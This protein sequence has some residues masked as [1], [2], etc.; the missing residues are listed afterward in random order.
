MKS[1]SS[2]GCFGQPTGRVWDAVRAGW[3]ALEHK[4]DEMTYLHRRPLN[5]N[6]LTEVEVQRL[7]VL[8]AKKHRTSWETG[9]AHALLMRAPFEVHER[10][11][12]MLASKNPKGR[13][14][15]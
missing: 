5:L 4:E 2:C 12:P 3:I 15:S 9:E 13:R 8:A 14:A 1:R 11:K 10:L 7:E 6:P